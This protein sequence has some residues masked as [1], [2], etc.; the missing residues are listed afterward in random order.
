MNTVFVAVLFLCVPTNCIFATTPQ[1]VYKTETQCNMEIAKL[2]QEFVTE[3]PNGV[4][5]G[6]CIKVTVGE[7]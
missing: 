3:I 6:I 7:T 2:A 5:Q 1:Q 4:S